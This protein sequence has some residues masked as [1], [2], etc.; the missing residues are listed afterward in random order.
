MDI[1][2]QTASEVK[3]AALDLGKTTVSTAHDIA[4]GVIAVSITLIDALINMKKNKHVDIE[5]GEHTLEK[6]KQSLV[7]GDYLANIK[8]PDKDINFFKDAM[9]KEGLAFAVLDENVD[10]YKTVLFMHSGAGKM[11]NVIN[12]Y[13]AR[14]G[15]I[16]E[17]EPD[18]FI[19]HATDKNI[20]TVF[21]IDTAE[22]ELFRDRAKETELV[23]S[24][25]EKGGKTVL[26]YEPKD[27]SLV[28]KMLD[29]VAWDMSGKYGKRLA[30]GLILRRAANREF[31][32]AVSGCGEFFAVNAKNRDNYITVTD[33][34]LAYCKNDSVV[35]HIDR[36][37]KFFADK[38]RDK[39]KGL[40]NP[41]SLSKHE[42]ELPDEERGLIIKSRG[43]IYSDKIAKEIEKSRD[44]LKNI[45]RKMSLDDENDN[46]SQVF[47]DAV[48]YSDYA[49]YEEMS[50]ID[51]EEMK[52]Q[53][54]KFYN[55]RKTYEYKEIPAKN[56]SLDN[57]IRNAEKQ[58]DNI[59][60]KD[61][62]HRETHRE[63][64]SEQRS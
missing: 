51:R 20:G 54:K 13:H 32:N 44:R 33:A 19:R 56:R 8:I 61:I 5:A 63:H 64:E 36:S 11:E 15:L 29:A 12:L 34:G 17:I 59:N 39:F 6:M 18:V 21:N 3:R 35:A 1:H 46:P 62:P 9:Q 42:F 60:S 14:E 52:E 53:F 30:D 37:D 41:V 45:I 24:F 40:Q 49:G 58:K 43:N 55:K 16:H 28:N 31:E 4:E 57:I 22:F 23:Y 27:K 2:E 26:L 10:A 7:N 48:S 50:D 47:D 38:A 25:Y